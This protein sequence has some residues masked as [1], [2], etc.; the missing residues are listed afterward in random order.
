MWSLV[1]QRGGWVLIFDLTE[2]WGH[3]LFWHRS[4]LTAIAIGLP[5]SFTGC[6][7]QTQESSLVLHVHSYV[8]H[9]YQSCLTPI[10]VLSQHASVKFHTITLVSHISVYFHTD[11]SSFTHINVVSH[12][13]NM[14]SHGSAWSRTDQSRLTASVGQA[15]HD[16]SGVTRI[17]LV[18][19]V[20]ISLVIS[21]GSV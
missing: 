19:R 3:G 16:Q 21:R 10:S 8:S 9:T 13:I 20:C 6:K 17:G 18:L 12:G 14:V 11:Q 5:S 4:R 7:K 1:N 15:A 2:G